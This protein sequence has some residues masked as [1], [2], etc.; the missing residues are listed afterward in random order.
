M[1]FF[2]FEATSK[3]QSDEWAPDIEV[4]FHSQRSV[5]RVLFPLTIMK[6]GE[7]G[8]IVLFGMMSFILVAVL[9]MKENDPSILRT[10]MSRR[11]LFLKALFVLAFPFWIWAIVNTARDASI[12]L[13]VV[14]FGVVLLTTMVALYFSRNR[15]EVRI[16]GYFV[17][18][19][20]ILVAA[21]YGLSLFYISNEPA[22]HFYASSGV[23]V[24]V[25][26]GLCV[27]KLHHDVA[28]A[29][30]EDDADYTKVPGDD[31]N[32]L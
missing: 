15:L 23:A 7:P 18:I 9:Q 19:A 20:C 14:S 26:S 6:L 31:Q 17:I 4:D 5:R 30:S 29:P 3:V 32:T 24:W 2:F 8:L 13:G 27:L 22:Y 21:N 10:A 16:S 1:D 12:D 11:Q 28:I 25:I